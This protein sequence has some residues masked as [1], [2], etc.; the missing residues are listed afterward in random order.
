MPSGYARKDACLHV[1]VF[2]F[3]LLLIY[4]LILSLHFTALQSSKQSLKLRHKTHSLARCFNHIPSLSLFFFSSLS[5]LLLGQH[6]RAQRCYHVVISTLSFYFLYFSLYSLT[7]YSSP[8]P[9]RS[10]LRVQHVLSRL[11]AHMY[12]SLPSGIDNQSSSLFHLLLCVLAFPPRRS[13]CGPAFHTIS[14][15]PLAF[16]PFAPF[17]SL[18]SLS[19]FPYR[20]DCLISQSPRL[21]T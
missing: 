19:S 1:I 15:D 4:L 7:N 12:L 18:S 5:I 14:A 20:D 8:A 17:V 9:S 13:F 2:F 10:P 6:L 21:A 3:S 16:A 11:V